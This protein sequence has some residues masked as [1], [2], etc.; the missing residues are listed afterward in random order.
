MPFLPFHTISQDS[1]G[2]FRT[3]LSGWVVQKKMI[4][5]LENASKLFFS[6]RLI[7]KKIIKWIRKGHAEVISDKSEPFFFFLTQFSTLSLNYFVL[8]AQM[9]K[10]SGSIQRI[11]VCI[12]KAQMHDCTNR[13]KHIG[14]K[15]A[16]ALIRIKFLICALS[17]WS[18]LNNCPNY[19][20]RSCTIR[21]PSFWEF[22]MVD[23]N[24]TR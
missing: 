4:F 22:N 24:K 14:I 7:D 19:A 1:I 9:H 11:C 8:I 2:R 16:L 21:D 12:Y 17:Q 20:F 15:A 6:K 3:G 10:L 23:G 5:E 13:W 18:W